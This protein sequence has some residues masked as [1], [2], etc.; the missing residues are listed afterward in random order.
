MNKIMNNIGMTLTELLA[1]TL[2]MLLVSMG[3]ATGVALS[4]KEFTYSIK[5]SEA[6]ELF[7]TLQTILSNELRYTSNVQYDTNGNVTYFFTN[8]YALTKKATY[9]VV[10]T[11]DDDGNETETTTE[12]GEVAFGSDG[13]YNRVI[14]SGNY[15]YGLGAK[16]NKLTYDVTSKVFTV[17]LA[18]GTNDN[19]SII[20][21]TFNVRA[22]NMVD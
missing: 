2:I 9:L 19:G 22:L 5:N 20:D 17:E 15:S 1:A 16:I 6:Q 14:G 12:Y 10:I 8:T 3:V 4:N 11:T 7:S 21:K 18:I 13:T